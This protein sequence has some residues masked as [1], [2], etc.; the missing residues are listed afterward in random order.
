MQVR[1][2]YNSIIIL[3][4]LAAPLSSQESKQDSIANKFSATIPAH[5]FI[6]NNEY[7]NPYTDG[8]TSIGVIVQP[9]A[10][11]HF[12]EKSKLTAGLHVLKYSGLNS[13]SEIIPLIRFESQLLK[14]LKLIVGNI[15]GASKHGLSEPLYRYDLDYQNR[16]EYGVQI[17]LKSNTITSDAWLHW[18]QFIEKNDPFPEEL[19]VGNMTKFKL[20]KNDVF[21]FNIN[22]E[23]LLS[24]VGGQIDQASNPDRTL[25]NYSLSTC[26]GFLRDDFTLTINPSY[27]NFSILNGNQMS[28]GQVFLGTENG[29]G[30][31]YQLKATIKQFE[32]SIGY[33]DVTDFY[34]PIGEPLFFSYNDQN[35]NLISSDRSLMTSTIHFPWQPFDYLN[36][37]VGYRGYYDTD[38]R[39]FDYAIYFNCLVSL[40]LLK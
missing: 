24:H 23:F 8:F 18:E 7:F 12:D 16:V 36:L 9:S 29:T 2:I 1:S 19:F 32:L 6:K 25:L 40:Y 34:S 31:W 20:V 27:Y 22:T 30:F 38:S 37:D 13:F 15:D 17:L 14:S 39:Q 11:Y 33:W 35:R 28:N 3:L 26:I 21:K 10:S 4:F 5:F